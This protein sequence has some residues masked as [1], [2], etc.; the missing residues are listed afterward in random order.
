MQKSGRLASQVR[1]INKN[2]A[3]FGEFEIKGSTWTPLWAAV[4]ILSAI[5][6][7]RIALPFSLLRVDTKSLCRKKLKNLFC[8][9]CQHVGVISPKNQVAFV[10]CFLI[11]VISFFVPPFLDSV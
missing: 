11:L 10:P 9:F 6:L 3:Y 5:S 8:F 1:G 2:S 4:R 7:S